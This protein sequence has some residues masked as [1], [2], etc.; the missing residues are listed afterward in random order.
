M[1]LE[2]YRAITNLRMVLDSE[3]DADSPDNE[4]TYKALRE[5]IEILYQLMVDTG[6]SGTVTT[7]AETVL[8]DSGAS[9]DTDEHNGR[10]LLMCSGDAKGNFYTID[11]T[12]ST[13]LTCTGDTLVSDGVAIG[14]DYK[15]LYDIKTNSDGHDHDGVNSKSAILADDVVTLEKVQHGSIMLP[16]HMPESDTELTTT[17]ASWATVQ[18]ML[19]YIPTGATV[20]TMAS[21]QYH[22]TGNTDMRCRF[23]VED[24]GNSTMNADN[25]LS[26]DWYTNA[27]LDVS[28]VSGWKDLTVE[29][30]LDGATGTGYLQGFSLIW[31]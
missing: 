2:I 7:I 11:D 16:L 10:T 19:I 12:A 8:T 24:V 21:R 3:T 28:A 20:I 5:M 13:T 9:F 15:V 17:S 30:E 26:Y 14:D 29:I 25:N 27:T 1:S 22:S 31:E 18:K 23:N 4:T 6:D